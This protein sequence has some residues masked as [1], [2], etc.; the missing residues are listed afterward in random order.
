MHKA[1]AAYA[2]QMK[3]QVINKAEGAQVIRGLVLARLPTGEWSAP[4]CVAR[5]PWILI[6]LNDEAA[7]RRFARDG[8]VILRGDA[9]RTIKDATDLRTA[10]RKYPP[11]F[12]F[13]TEG[14][15][16]GQSMEGAILTELTEN[17]HDFYGRPV[18]ARDL[19]EGR[20][21]QPEG[22]SRLY[23]VIKEAE[24]GDESDTQPED[25]KDILYAAIPSF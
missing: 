23:R 7:I 14:L 5:G 13:M 9:S 22:A 3:S 4:S 6:V 16:T 15:F 17:N 11:M 8:D 12:I 20:F 25:E 2:D 10:A 1:G 24:G 18:S 21:R 19:L